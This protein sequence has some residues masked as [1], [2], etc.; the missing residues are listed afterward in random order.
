MDIYC[1]AL[2]LPPLL[3]AYRT[4]GFRQKYIF[5]SMQKIG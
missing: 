5:N 3:F 2:P 4:I 1:F